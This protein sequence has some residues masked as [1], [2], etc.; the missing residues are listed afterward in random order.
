[1]AAPIAEAIL[2]A[3]GLMPTA[4]SAAPKMPSV[5]T[6]VYL[7]AIRPVHDHVISQAENDGRSP[8]SRTRSLDWMIAAQRLAWPLWLRGIAER[9]L[10][11]A[12][13]IW[14]LRQA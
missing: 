7:D 8:P 1:L 4:L 12:V 3:G 13:M 10:L 9:Q 11:R 6:A 14:C 2:A 5:S